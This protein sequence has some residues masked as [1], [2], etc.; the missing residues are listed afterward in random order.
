MARRKELGSIASGIIGSFNSRNNDVDGYWGVGKLCSFAYEQLTQVVQ[1]EI[2]SEVINP[3]TEQ[4]NSLLIHYQNILKSHLAKRNIPIKWLKNV[5]IT[6]SFNQP[7]QNK[8]HLWR[9]ACGKP[10]ICVC[11]IT[12]DNGRVHSAI[13]GGNCFPHNPSK[14]LR[15]AYV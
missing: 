9:T 8:Y 6:I 1:I 3:K 14:E 13:A 15:R 5:T 2:L 4:F 10:Y 7:F 11:E 12:D